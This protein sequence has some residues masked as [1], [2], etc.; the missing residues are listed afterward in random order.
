MVA[1]FIL[2]IAAINFMNLATARSTKRAREIGVR[3][4]VGATKKALISQ[5]MGEAMLIAIMALVVAGIL[6]ELLLPAYNE[7]TGKSISIDYLDPTYLL[8]FIGISVFTGFLSGIYPAL[9][10]SSFKV[11]H[12]TERQPQIP[13]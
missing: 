10:L 2:L 3:K 4:V 9:F 8:S 6:V 7:L 13:L 11:V 5:F 12:V 1:V